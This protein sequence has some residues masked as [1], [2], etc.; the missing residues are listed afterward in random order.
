[1]SIKVVVNHCYGGFGLSEIA[2]SLV[3][4]RTGSEFFPW[5]HPR[6]CPV[7]VSVV[8]ELGEAANG[9]CAELS[10]AELRWGNR[11]IIE[12][13]DGCENVC[14]PEQINWITA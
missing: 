14:E 9:E 4:E 1:M 2:K 12:A 11:Y 6:H 5:E 13:Y 8:E 10:V 7:L 3:E